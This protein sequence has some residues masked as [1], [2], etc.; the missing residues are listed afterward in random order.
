VSNS[1]VLTNF[2]EERHFEYNRLLAPSEM[3]S[4]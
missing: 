1:E 3:K 2:P 4:F